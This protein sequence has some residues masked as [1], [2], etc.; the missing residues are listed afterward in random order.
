[1]NAAADKVDESGYSLAD[2]LQGVDE[3]GPDVNAPAIA[4]TALQIAK[5]T[6]LRQARAK[7]SYSLILKHVT[8]QDHKSNMY[9]QHF[10][11]GYGAMEYMR[12]ACMQPINAMQ[13]RAMDK[14]WDALNILEECGVDAYSLQNFAKKMRVMNGLR[15]EANRHDKDAMTMRF[16]ECLFTISSK[17]QE[18][19]STEFIDTL[20]RR[21]TDV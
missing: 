11:D 18:S 4:G 1:M 21:V 19:A 13:L 2:Y 5:K 15:P 9:S 17:Y 8:D 12:G 20:S 7:S 3:G 14:E 6:K 10:Q 16:L